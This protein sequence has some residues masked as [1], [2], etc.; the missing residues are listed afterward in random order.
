MKPRDAPA[1]ADPTERQVTVLRRTAVNAVS[2]LLAYV[3]PRLLIFGAAVVAARVL[4]ASGFGAYG[5]AAALAVILS[6]LSTLGMMP[7]LIRGIARDPQSAPS[8]IFAAHVVKTLANVLMLSTLFV[9]AR[10]VLVYPAEVVTAGM[11]LGTAY[12]IGSYGET[13]GAYFQ[14][15]E[16][17]HIWMQA[18]A[19]LGVVTGVV[20]VTLV[21]TTAS[22]ELFCLA[23]V[24][25]QV[26]AVAWLLKR[27]PAAVRGGTASMDD[28]RR[29]LGSIAPFALG[30]TVLTMYYK[31]DVLLLARFRTPSEVGVYAAAYKFVDVAQALAVVGVGALY[32]RL[33]RIHAKGADAGSVTSRRLMELTLLIVIPAAGVLW[34]LR[35]PLV[36][37]LFDTPYGEAAGVVALLA[38]ALPAL[39]INV[40]LSFTLAAAERMWLVAWVY[41]AGL[42]VNIT[43]NWMLIPAL[44]SPGAAL[45]MLVS[46]NAVGVAF[47]LTAV[48][49]L[50]ARPRT[51]PLLVG[52]AAVATCL[53]IVPFQEQLGWFGMGAVYAVVVAA[54]YRG[55][56]VFDPIELEA[57]RRAFPSPKRTRETSRLRVRV[58]P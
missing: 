15:I 56:R 36:Q 31:I 44:G 7:L 9:L 22:V 41:T 24:L 38:P 28:V 48:V 54:I 50:G 46:E 30:F 8:L 14:G 17:M 1:A 10:W 2:L 16:R 45:A 53:L 43:L 39:A 19:L 4:G 32:P 23:P 42:A 34:L 20:G 58:E 47:L 35:S 37:V 5:V 3:L 27:A 6:V 13:L 49:V 33:A 52:A 26:A 51:R 11:L 21:V 57:V 18:N 12:A 29:L 55:A 25:G 40:L